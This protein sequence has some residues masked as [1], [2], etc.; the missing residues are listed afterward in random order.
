[1][2]EGLELA[3][4]EY[5]IAFRKGSDV[6]EKVNEIILELV[7]TGLSRSGGKIRPEPCSRYCRI[8]AKKFIILQN[9]RG[10]GRFCALWPVA[11]IRN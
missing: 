10:R 6:T 8:K 3:A 9:N 5:G 11:L 4:E 7:R 2:V 1:M